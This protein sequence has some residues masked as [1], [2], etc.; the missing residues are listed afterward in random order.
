MTSKGRPRSF[1]VNQ[2]LDRALEVFWSKGYEGTS[3]PDLTQAMGINRPSLYAAFGNKEALFRKV[4]DRYGESSAAYTQEALREP[5]SRA[6]AEHLL[7]GSIALT[8]KPEHPHGCLL[9]LGGLAGGEAAESMRQEMINRRQAGEIAIR[10]RFERA[11]AE[12]DLPN[13]AD[14]ADLARFIATLNQGLSV[15]AA[16]GASREE[17][18]RVARI[19]LQAWPRP[20]PPQ[21]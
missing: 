13:D 7:F 8:T 19:A 21:L 6:V 5:T 11:K 1:D 16:A 3:L 2:A 12:G 14:P 18:E 4:L 20:K 9:V 17:L 10:E 15:Q